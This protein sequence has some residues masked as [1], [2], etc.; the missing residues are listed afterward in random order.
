MYTSIII[1]TLNCSPIKFGWKLVLTTALEYEEKYRSLPKEEKDLILFNKDELLAAITGLHEA[2]N[3]FVASCTDA[4]SFDEDTKSTNPFDGYAE[5]LN[6]R[7]P[8]LNEK[9]NARLLHLHLCAAMNAL[10]TSPI[11]KD[12]APTLKGPL[13]GIA[14][15]KTEAPKNHMSTRVARSSTNAIAGCIALVTVKGISFSPSR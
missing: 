15:S 1:K 6:Q 7:M 8:V 5:L 4:S 14:Y 3:N 10:K 12:T 9:T 11:S 2:R 13:D